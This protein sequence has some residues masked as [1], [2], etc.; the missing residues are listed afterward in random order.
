MMAE[1]SSPVRIDLSSLRDLPMQVKNNSVG[2]T[3]R[4]AAAAKSRSEEISPI[5]VGRVDGELYPINEFEAVTGLRRAGVDYVDAFVTDYTSMQD[6]LGTHV[7]RNMD[8]QAVEPLLV[9]GMVEYVMNACRIGVAE[10]CRMMWLDSRPDL[11]AAIGAQITAEA[12][13]VL[14]EMLDE[15]S[16]KVY[17]TNTPAYYVSRLGRIRPDEQRDAASELKGMTMSRMTPSDPDAWL[18]LESVKTVIRGFHTAGREVPVEERMMRPEDDVADI[19]KKRKKSGGGNGG[20]AGA[21]DL[22]KAS[23]YISDDNNLVYVPMDGKFNDLVVN[24][25]TGRVG[26]VRE[27]EGVCAVIDDLGKPSLVMTDKVG[28]YIGVDGNNNL[29]VSVGLYSTLDKA[30]RMLAKAKDPN[31]RC[32]VLAIGSLPRR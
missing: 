5:S 4:I 13:T 20:A 10:A 7:R 16:H 17:Q 19:L 1:K 18:A 8:Q 30:S 14:M 12:H 6:L 11:V 29:D 31:R 24:K 23:R 3:R 21:R 27:Q 26:K 25:K 28:R 32:A 9:R 15:V 2:L 22:D